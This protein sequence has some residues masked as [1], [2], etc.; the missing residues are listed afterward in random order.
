M[1]KNI[2]IYKSR[3]GFAKQYA[4]F[5]A[6]ELKADIIELSE[7]AGKDLKKY[8]CII[9]GAG[10]YAS[11]INGIKEFKK[12]INENK[13]AKIKVFVTTLSNTNNE[14]TLKSLADKNFEKEIQERIEFYQLRGGIDYKKLNPL[15]KIMMFMLIKM[16]KNKKDKDEDMKMM[17]ETYGQKV[18]FTDKKSIEKIVTGIR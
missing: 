14:N 16:L 10:V 17:V 13:N 8:D 7:V 9:L 4:K 15:H 6:D 3:Y 5:I 11:S 1:S 18:D 12:I 2:V